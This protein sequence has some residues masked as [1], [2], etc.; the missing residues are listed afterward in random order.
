MVSDYI[1]INSCAFMQIRLSQL[2]FYIKEKNL[3][4]GVW[5]EIKKMFNTVL[6]MLNLFLYFI[7]KFLKNMMY[8]I[9]KMNL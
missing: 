2:T 5:N 1:S 8:D 3:I 6:K 4:L 9:L 7:S